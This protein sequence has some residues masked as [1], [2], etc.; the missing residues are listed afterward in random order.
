M[1]PCRHGSRVAGD[2]PPTL[3]KAVV[4]LIDSKVCN[5]TSVYRG[6]I[7]HNM[8]CAGFLQGKVD[9][10]QVRGTLCVCLHG[11]VCVYMG[12]FTCVVCPPILWGSSGVC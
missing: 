6:A 11:C 1:V 5:K 10:C 4:K 8:M 3:Q 12:V 9:S 7:T 2:I